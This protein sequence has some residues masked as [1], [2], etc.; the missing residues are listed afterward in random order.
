MKDEKREKKEKDGNII[1]LIVIAIVTMIVVVI[2]ATF[3]YLASTVDSEKEN[4]IKAKTNGTSDLLAFEIPNEL[5][6]IVDSDDLCQIDNNDC[7]DAIEYVPAKVTYQTNSNESTSIKYQVSLAVEE[8]NNN[9]EYTSGSCDPNYYN[10][11]LLCQANGGSWTP[12][13]NPQPELV[14]Y[15]YEEDK[16]N[17]SCDYAPGACFSPDYNSIDATH[18]DKNS[19]EGAHNVWNPFVYASAK[20]SVL[21]ENS[22]NS[23]YE[24]AE[25]TCFKLSVVKD[26]TSLKNGT[27]PLYLDGVTISSTKVN[28]SFNYYIAAVSMLNLEHN[29]AQNGQKEF[30]GSLKFS[31][32]DS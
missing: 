11:M 14:F 12:D 28:T 23:L 3:A 18:Q 20:G 27:I 1:F 2:G 7:Q 5:N 21:F 13:T 4:S 9:F 32:I 10:D 6:L 8:G 15:L 19:C 17:T 24:E 25:D 26:I 16:V 31:H 29:Q 22:D 30:S